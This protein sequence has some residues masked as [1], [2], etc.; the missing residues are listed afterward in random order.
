MNRE[1]EREKEKRRSMQRKLARCDETRNKECGKTERGRENIRPWPTSRERNEDNR[2]KKTISH[3]MPG[4]F[5]KHCQL[6]A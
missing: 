4:A 1:R 5:T 6:K 2:E 3:D